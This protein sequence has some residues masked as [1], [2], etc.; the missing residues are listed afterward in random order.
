MHLIS[1][2]ADGAQKLS[3]LMAGFR[4]CDLS[5]HLEAAKEG[6]SVIAEVKM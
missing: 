6:K 5:A 2:D 1:F 4:R 3:V